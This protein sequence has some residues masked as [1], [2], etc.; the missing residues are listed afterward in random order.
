MSADVCIVGA[1]VAGALAAFR[2]AAGGKSVVLLD[3]G[4]RFEYPDMARYE[5][6]RRSIYPWDWFDEDRDDYEEEATPRIGLNSNRIKAIGGTTLHWSANAQRFQPGDFRMRT[7]FG[8]GADWPFPY[9][10]LEPWYL[11]AEREMGVAGGS[12]PDQP[13]RSAP[14]PLPPHEVSFAEREFIVP[15]FHALGLSIAPNSTATNSQ[16]YD[17]RPR[18]AAFATCNPFC[19]INAKY[20]ATVHVAKAE[21]S[22]RVVVKPDSHVR[23]VVLEGRRKVSHVECVDRNGTIWRERARAFVLAGGG[24]EIP[25][26]LLLSATDG[27]HDQGLANSSGLVG[28]NYMT[29]PRIIVRGRLSERIGPHRTGVDTT[30]SWAVYQH[31]TLPGTGNVMLSPSVSGGPEPADIALESGL[32]G[33]ELVEEV[34]V[35]YGY[36]VGIHAKGDMLPR[37]D[38]RVTLSS[39][40][41]DTY[42]DPIPRIEMQLGEF[43]LNAI[44]EG[45]KVAEAIFRQMNAREIWRSNTQIVRNHI[46]GTTR[47]GSDPAD[48]VCDEWGRCHDLD[49][50]FVSSSSLFP[51][52]AC[53]SPTLTIAALA[54]RTGDFLVRNV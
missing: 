50:L 33:E 12:G 7:L 11:L 16:P 13:P 47:M 35:R 49:N 1:G 39:S 25:R 23:R 46:I 34:R 3:S 30:N 54:L 20:T 14:Y 44:D 51:S 26:L 52:A 15:A 2:L 45:A 38:N 36:E 21:A 4:P 28:R 6:V 8:L 42:G 19:P 37:P 24:V 18:C 43:E 5:R 9:D 40:R 27:G 32:W 10:E 41:V 17:G 31:R 53:S 22:G 48:S 29:H